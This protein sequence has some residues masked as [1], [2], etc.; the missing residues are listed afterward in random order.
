MIEWHPHTD[1]SLGIETPCAASRD[2]APIARLSLT[3]KVAVGR[4]EPE[5]ILEAASAPA[6]KL[7]PK[8]RSHSSMA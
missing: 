5:H 7:S 8:L 2:I 3:A 4:C 1:M 6:S